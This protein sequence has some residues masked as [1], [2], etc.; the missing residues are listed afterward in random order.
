MQYNC[1]TF[2]VQYALEW[3]CNQRELHLQCIAVGVQGNRPQCRLR[4]GVADLHAMSQQP[5]RVI[6]NT[7]RLVKNEIQLFKLEIQILF[8]F[9]F[10]HWL[11]PKKFKLGKP[12]LG[13]STMT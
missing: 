11:S 7:A 13:E 10:F 4:V 9:Y 12:R 5:Q 8:T 6:D 2:A 1:L 3:Y